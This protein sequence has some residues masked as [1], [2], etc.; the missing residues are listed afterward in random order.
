MQLPTIPIPEHEPIQVTSIELRR[1]RLTLQLPFKTS[2]GTQRVRDTVL[3]FMRTT[4]DLLGVGEAPSLVAPIFDHQ[5]VWSD[6]DVLKRFLAPA[7][8]EGHHG[9]INSLSTLQNIFKTIKAHHFSK[10]GIEGAYWH[11]VAQITQTPLQQLWGGTGEAVPA[12]FS[13]G[14][15]SIDDVLQ[16]AEA[17][18]NSG[19]QRLKIKIWPGFER[20]VVTAVRAA[21]PDIMLQVDANASYDPAN[22]EHVMALKALDE[23]DLLLIEQ[24]FAANRIFDHAQFQ[25]AADLKTPICLDE[26]LSDA[27]DARQAIDIWQMMGLEGRLIL[28]IKP[29]RVGGFAEALRIAEIGRQNN[30]PCWTGGMLE[31]VVGKWMNAIFASHPACTLPGDHVQPQPYYEQ[32]IGTPIPTAD[33]NGTIKLPSDVNPVVL[34]WYAIDA[35]TVEQH[36]IMLTTDN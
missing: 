3:V 2:F 33:A 21:H 22:R 27:H 18:V 16:R 19:I 34:D 29:P 1:V 17:A 36:E 25:K 26:A 11:L 28:N 24:P 7:L 9:Q 13:I 12:G 8:M 32:D 6:V 20:D 4:N 31:T 23:L 5:Y 15:E 10:C 14:G 30:V 35:L